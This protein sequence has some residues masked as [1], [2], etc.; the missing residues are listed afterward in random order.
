[1]I[2]AVTF[3]SCET[4]TS[5][6]PPANTVVIDTTKTVNINT[7]DVDELRRIPYVGDVLA[8]RIIDFRTEH[9]PFESSEQ[10]MLV[11]GMS[12]KRFRQIRHLIYVNAPQ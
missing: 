3:T 4:I 9:G 10:L 7:A 6:P 11:Q 5:P 12:D 1:M 8:G 2:S